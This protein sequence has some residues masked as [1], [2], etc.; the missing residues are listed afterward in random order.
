MSS[1]AFAEFDDLYEIVEHPAAKG[2]EYVIRFRQ[3]PYAGT[4]VQVS[5]FTITDIEGS[6]ESQM[7]FQY[8]IL[9]STE[10]P[11]D[12]EKYADFRV[13]VSRCVLNMYERV[14]LED[15]NISPAETITHDD[16]SVEVKYDVR[17]SK[18]HGEVSQ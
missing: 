14:L 3:A 15:H 1:R 2:G 7:D 18:P 17:T 13:L 11:D 6:E 8:N 16:G 9:E 4:V 5:E 12:L 10:S